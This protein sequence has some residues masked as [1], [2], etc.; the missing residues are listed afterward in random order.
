MDAPPVQYVKTSDGY[1]IAY[2]AR[3][4]GRPLV[5]M[6][7]PFSNIRG[8]WESRT[9]RPKFERLAAAFKLIQYDCR[10]EGM[11]K[12]PL[13]ANARID[14]YVRD[15]E[16]VVALGSNEPV[17]LLATALSG[18]TAVQYAVQRPDRVA[19]LILFG[20]SADDPL[21]GVRH[22]G[23]LA[24][25]SWE[26]F[27]RVVAY[28]FLREDPPGR[29]FQILD[30]AMGPEDFFRKI[31]LPAASLKPMLPLVKVPTLVVAVRG[32]LGPGVKG[33]DEGK[34]IAAAIPGARFL[35]FGPGE[36]DAAAT[37]IDFAAELPETASPE[38]DAGMEVGGLS[39]R[40]V[41]ILR[42][43]A[44]GR[45]NQ[46][47]A[48][49]LVISPNTVRRHVSNVFDKIGATNRAQAAIYAKD[50]GIA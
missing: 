5:W 17:L 33:E 49:E 30:D 34:A 50:H 23:E 26:N 41:D 3:G 1:D 15:L 11:S 22:L 35:L 29:A 44:A 4:T 16:A 46:Q 28:N 12:R 9:W 8:Q 6:P 14:D 42:L 21:H 2:V 13:S 18:Y 31:G 19:G 43:L 32:E 25:D 45:S 47:I 27:L 37:A 39:R 7:L 40:E 36:T 38:V 20:V 24:R 48:D 10:G